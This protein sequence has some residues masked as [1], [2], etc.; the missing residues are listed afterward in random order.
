MPLCYKPKHSKSW[1][2]KCSCCQATSINLLMGLWPH[3]VRQNTPLLHEK[4]SLNANVRDSLGGVCFLVVIFSSLLP[5][6]VR[7][8]RWTPGFR[9]VAL[10]VWKALLS[11]HISLLHSDAAQ[12]RH[13]VVC[14]E[15]IWRYEAIN[16]ALSF[17]ICLMRFL[18]YG[19]KWEEKLIIREIS[20]YAN[21]IT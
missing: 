7:P 11:G 5:G 12:N 21:L 3:K 6:G 20:I 8:S 19:L 15:S 17:W 14:S 16:Y 18:F 9:K 13:R 10:G 1:Q 2:K 4:I